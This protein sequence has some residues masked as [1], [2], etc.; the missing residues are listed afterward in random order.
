M[1]RDTLTTLQTILEWLHD[2]EADTQCLRT[3][4]KVRMA[5]VG[6]VWREREREGGGNR[7]T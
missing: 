3:Y 6:R 5:R 7:W 1:P 2:A 4:I